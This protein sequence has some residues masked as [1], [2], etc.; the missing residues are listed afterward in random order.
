MI[1]E[2][3]SYRDYPRLWRTAKDIIDL[4]Q[5]AGAVPL[6]HP[7]ATCG[8]GDGKAWLEWAIDL[9]SLCPERSL[10]AVDRH[11]LRPSNDYVKVPV[12]IRATVRVM[13]KQAKSNGLF[14]RG[15]YIVDQFHG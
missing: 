9:R 10:M 14:S 15:I 3:C 13:W 12:S 6:G 1:D 7:V 8:K 2:R 11:Y 4:A 5:M